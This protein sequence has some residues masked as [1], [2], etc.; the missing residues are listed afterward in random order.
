MMML[1]GCFEELILKEKML[2]QV[3]KIRKEKVGGW[4]GRS[5]SQHRQSQGQVFC[6]PGSSGAI[7]A[8]GR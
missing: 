5:A 6:S 7:V 3:F 1:L 2:T 8:E 4:Q